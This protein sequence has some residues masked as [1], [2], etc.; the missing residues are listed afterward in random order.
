MMHQCESCPSTATLKG[1]LDQ[2]LNKHED[3]E[4][5]YYW[6]WD[7]IDRAILATFTATYKECK[8]TL[9]YVIDDLTRHSCIT[10]LK[11]YQFLTQSEI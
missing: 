5:F 10:K 11:N 6:R 3:D 7:A 9:T 4:K 1:F 2:E 8:E